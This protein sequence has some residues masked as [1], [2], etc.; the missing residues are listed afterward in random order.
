MVL[1]AE[2][3]KGRLFPKWDVIKIATIAVAV[4]QTIRKTYFNVDEGH[5]ALKFNR[6]TG[7]KQKV[8]AEG[9]HFTFPYLE[10]PITFDVRARPHLFKGTAGTQ[11]LQMVEISLRVLA[12]PDLTYL[13]SLYRRLGEKY[14]EVV[15]PSIVQETL[16]GTVAKYNASQ[17]VTQRETV[18]KDICTLLAEKASS[19]YIEVDDV[20]ITDISFGT[21][22]NAAIEA[23]QIAAQEVERAMYIV[24]KAE[25]EKKSA[26]IK[27]KGE[28]QSAVLIGKAIGNNQS[29]ISLR[30]IEAS[31]EIAES[32]AKSQNRVILN[33]D[34]LMLDVKGM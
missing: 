19:F 21:E 24:E 15:F 32:V 25:Q 8:Y 27:A 22:F 17:L 1:D 20:S 23:K 10:W 33:A 11:D 34:D 16:R 31:K 12:R 29:F 30:K 18:S 14:D 9:T 5:R 7:T 13:A 3:V 28:A 2:K 26:I 6:I 4:V